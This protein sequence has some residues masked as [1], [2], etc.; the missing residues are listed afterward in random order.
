MTRR[1]FSI[2]NGDQW[3]RPIRD[4]TAG[5]IYGCPHSG[6]VEVEPSMEG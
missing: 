3:L 1:Q 4:T 2:Q 5:S 6:L